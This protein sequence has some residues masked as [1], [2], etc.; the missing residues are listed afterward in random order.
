MR[1]PCRICFAQTLLLEALVHLGGLRVPWIFQFFCKRTCQNIWL[2]R[3]IRFPDPAQ[4][5]EFLE[6]N[7]S[8]KNGHTSSWVTACYLKTFPLRWMHL[9]GNLWAPV[10]EDERPQYLV[11]RCLFSKSLKHLT[12]CNCRRFAYDRKNAH[13]QKCSI[14][15]ISGCGSVV[16]IALVLPA[17]VRERLS[18]PHHALIYIWTLSLLDDPCAIRSVI[19]TFDMGVRAGYDIEL[20]TFAQ[21][22]IKGWGSPA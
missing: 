22:T 2:K 14:P 17:Q 15:R 5:L 21:E 7:F 20:K 18:L 8:G 12:S 16:N 4:L 6:Q 1:K 9:C 11:R 10:S 19:G 13:A 3:S